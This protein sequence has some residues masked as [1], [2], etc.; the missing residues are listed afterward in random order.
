MRAWLV[1]WCW[2]GEHA[3]VEDPIVT[4]LSARRSSKQIQ[5]YVEQRYIEETAS[6]EEKLAYARYN[7]PQRPPYPAHIEHGRVHCGHNPWM[8]ATLVDDLEVTADLNGN[9]VLQWK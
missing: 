1:K 7:Q 8:E 9:E 4:V 3:A 6:L 2:Q 5:E